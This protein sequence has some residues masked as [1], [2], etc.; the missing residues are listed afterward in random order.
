[1]QDTKAD[2]VTLCDPWVRHVEVVAG[3]PPITKEVPP[4]LSEMNVFE[5]TNSVLSRFVQR[6]GFLEFLPTLIE[7]L[8]VTQFRSLSVGN[9]LSLRGFLFFRTNTMLPL[10]TE[11]RKNPFGVISV[12]H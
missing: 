8:E 9:F 5:K 7:L 3:P 11:R 2:D 4:S 6:K 1:M 12:D 10:Q